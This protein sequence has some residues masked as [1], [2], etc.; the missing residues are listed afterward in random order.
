MREA[1]PLA[2]DTFSWYA[3]DS[4]Y[5]AQPPLDHTP[6]SATG[7]PLPSP[8]WVVFATDI[9]HNTE[10]GV[11]CFALFDYWIVEARTGRMPWLKY[12][13]WQGKIYDVRN[14][15]AEQE[16]SEHFDHIHISV[17]TD[18]ENVSLGAW[19]ITPGGDVAAAENVFE[20]IEEGTR[21][22]A[23][24]QTETPAGYD[25]V[26]ANWLGKGLGMAGQD[27]RRGYAQSVSNSAKLDQLLAGEAGSID[28]DDLADRIVR[29]I[30]GALL[31]G[32]G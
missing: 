10:L 6:F 32:L 4:H 21:S 19:S 9:M 25:P 8:H 23:P 3:D 2:A 29:K 22:W 15:F 24:A 30:A 31:N 5:E 11:D 27:A 1:Y 18:Y 20:F 7:W 14:G 26:P 13:I 12:L 28:L 16:S 17:R